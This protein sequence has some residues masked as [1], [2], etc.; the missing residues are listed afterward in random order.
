[1]KDPHSAGE[2]EDDFRALREYI[3]ALPEEVFD[4]HTNFDVL[5]PEQRLVWLSQSIQFVWEARRKV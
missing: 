4:G 2:A 3:L 5:T 1:M